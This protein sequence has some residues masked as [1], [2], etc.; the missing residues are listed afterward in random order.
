MKWKGLKSNNPYIRLAIS[1]LGFIVFVIAV[2]AICSIRL[3]SLNKSTLYERI[4]L[5]ATQYSTLLHQELTY[6]DKTLEPIADAVENGTVSEEEALTLLMDHAKISQ[7]ALLDT[8]GSGVDSEGAEVSVDPEIYTGELKQGICTYYD[9]KEGSILALLQITT[10][11][12]AEK[13]FMM[14]YDISAFDSLFSNFN[15]GSEAWLVLTDAD[16]NIVYCFSKKNSSYLAEGEN[17]QDILSDASGRIV[18]MTDEVSRGQAGNKTITFGEDTRQVFYKS[19]GIDDWYLFLGV[20]ASYVNT[21]LSQKRVVM[22]DMIIWLSVGVVLFA[23]ALII[24]NIRDKKRGKVK[25]DGLV[26]LAETDQLTGLYNK[27]TTEKKIKE[28]IEANPGAQSL[29]FVLDIDN[30]KK[31]NDTLGHAFGDEVL[32]TIGQRIQME[33]RAS[34]IIGRAG[35][36]EFIILLKELKDDEII[37]REARKVERFFQGFEVGSYTKYTVTA[38]IG[39][40]VFPRDAQDF[41]SLY[42]SADQALYLAKKRGKNQLAF[43]KEPEGFGQSV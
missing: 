40:A 29:F 35:G 19:I 13:I 27:V 37:V 14:R 33:F 4:T 21:R 43:Y 30:F 7:A 15:L 9:D 16:W 26:Q 25:D 12:G 1:V 23:A 2:L 32:R 24:G 38:S 36:D 10:E 20:P 22:R 18:T 11:S 17:F 5:D 8:D 31:V 34:D 28:F 3:N 6:L 41:E 42:K 39:C